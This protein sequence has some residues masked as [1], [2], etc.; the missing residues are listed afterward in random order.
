MKVLYL[1]PLVPS[2]SGNGGKRAVYNHLEDLARTTTDV[3]LMVVDV[4]GSGE[5]LPAAFACFRGRVFRRALPLGASAKGLVAALCQLLFDP[6]PRAAAVVASS[7]ARRA[8]REM[9]RDGR[10]D[11]VVVDHLN[12]WSLL[13]GVATD[14]PIQYIAH[15]VE[16]DVLRDQRTHDGRSFLSG[17]RLSVELAK[18][19]RFESALLRR[20]TTVTAIASTD[21]ASALMRAVRA[22]TAVWPEL[23]DVRVQGWRPPGSRTLLFVGSAA[24]FPN[25]DAIEWLVTQFMPAV[26]R[27]V[28]DVVLRIAGTARAELADLAVPASVVF[29]GFV[30][31]AR[32]DELHRTCDLFVCPVVLGSGIKIKVLEASAYGLPIAAT[33]ES[34]GGIDYLRDAALVIGRDGAA[35][36]CAVIDLL[37]DV[38]R[39]AAASAQA[40]AQL[41]RARGARAPLLAPAAAAAEGAA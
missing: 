36:A 5:T 21:C 37:G 7:E 15:N 8:V 2:A 31:A 1:A 23:P 34:L 11:V 17:M 41:V 14:V 13:D 32:L 30:S 29:E 6:R 4:E 24:Y 35:A 27:L 33:R 40:T 39:L 9:L 22:K 16:S 38:E 12:A 18:M 26:N 19:V 3:D 10:H 28:P 25:R 20:A